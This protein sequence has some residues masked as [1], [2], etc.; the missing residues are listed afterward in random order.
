MK[1]A[2]LAWYI[3]GMLA[4]LTVLSSLVTF[5][6][7]AQWL[8]LILPAAFGSGA[9]LVAVLAVI[10]TRLPASH[11]LQRSRPTWALLVAAAV[12]LTL[13]VVLVG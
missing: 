10:L 1:I 5:A 7:P 9:I 3:S 11:R 4:L 8:A 2:W 6:P 13:I 12:A